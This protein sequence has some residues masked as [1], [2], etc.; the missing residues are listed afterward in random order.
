MTRQRV[1]AIAGATIV[2]IGPVVTGCAGP[3]EQKGDPNRIV[4]PSE[5]VEDIEDGGTQGG[6]EDEVD[7]ADAQ[8]EAAERKAEEAKKKAEE[9][10]KRLEETSGH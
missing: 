7:S 8:A 6:M 4:A 9:A 1:I 3:A 10:A 5:Y 2:A